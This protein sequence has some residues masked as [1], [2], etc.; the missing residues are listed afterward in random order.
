MNA[1]HTQKSNHITLSLSLPAFQLRRKHAI[2]MMWIRQSGATLVSN[3]AE[4]D[5]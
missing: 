2:A 4:S 3:R 1:I 5:T